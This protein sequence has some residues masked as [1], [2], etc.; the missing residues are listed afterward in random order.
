VTQSTSP[1]STIVSEALIDRHL[2]AINSLVAEQ[3]NL[4]AELATLTAEKRRTEADMWF[5]SPE[6]TATGRNMHAQYQTYGTDLPDS[7]GLQILGREAR[8]RA[9]EGEVDYHRL[10]LAHGR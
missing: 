3:S 6:T 7:L 5:A 1:A 2:D 10:C 9:I 4:M 8:V